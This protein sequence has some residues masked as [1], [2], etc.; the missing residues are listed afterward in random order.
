MSI[1]TS[2]AASLL[3]RPLVQFGS[4]FTSGKGSWTSPRPHPCELMLHCSDLCCC[5]RHK[6]LIIMSKIKGSERKKTTQKTIHWYKHTTTTTTTHTDPGEKTSS[7]VLTIGSGGWRWHLIA[8]IAFLLLMVWGASTHCLT[9]TYTHTCRHTQGH[10]QTSAVL[11][12]AACECKRGRGGG[13]DQATDL[14][15]RLDWRWGWNCAG[16]Q[17]ILSE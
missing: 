14:R 17:M 12:P 13:E 10:S 9:H 3:M 1:S 7:G 5:Q 2:S 11:T 4:L 8:S 6:P 16:Q 15:V